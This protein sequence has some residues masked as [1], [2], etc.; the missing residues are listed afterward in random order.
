MSARDFWYVVVES[1]FLVFCKKLN[2][3][4]CVRIKSAPEHWVFYTRKWGNI[5]QNCHYEYYSCNKIT[6]LGQNFLFF[7]FSLK[8]HAIWLKNK[9]TKTGLQNTG[10]VFYINFKWQY[11]SNRLALSAPNLAENIF[12]NNLMIPFYV[13]MWEF[14][15]HLL[16]YQLVNPDHINKTVKV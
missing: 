4:H 9:E 3:G 15:L 8:L 13:N 2:V 5:E 1:Y 10:S 6:L 7:A 14:F 11:L 16:L 12:W